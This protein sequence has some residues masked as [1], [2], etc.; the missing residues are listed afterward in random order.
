MFKSHSLKLLFSKSFSRFISLCFLCLFLSFYLSMFVV[1][2][3]LSFCSINLL[4]CQDIEAFP[5]P[6]V[7]KPASK[8]PCRFC[9]KKCEDLKQ[10]HLL[11]FFLADPQDTQIGVEFFFD[12]TWPEE[13]Q[14]DLNFFRAISRS[15]QNCFGR[16]YTEMKEDLVT[17]LKRV[18]FALFPW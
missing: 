11:F 17:R 12:L 18:I 6:E 10:D 7:M 9:W 14:T 5:S 4:L 16:F 1:S 2:L 15:S 13:G 3:F 8:R